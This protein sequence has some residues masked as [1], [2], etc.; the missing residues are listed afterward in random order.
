MSH[1]SPQPSPS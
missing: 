1:S